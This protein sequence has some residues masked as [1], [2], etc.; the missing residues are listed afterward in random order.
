MQLG[1]TSLRMLKKLACLAVQALAVLIVD[2]R[3]KRHIVSLA[4]RWRT[5]YRRRV[6]KEW[7]GSA[8]AIAGQDPVTSQ[9]TD[10]HFVKSDGRAPADVHLRRRDYLTPDEVKRLLAAARSGRHGARPSHAVADVP[11][12]AAGQRVDRPAADDL[13]LTSDQLWVQLLK[14]GLSTSQQPARDELRAVRRHLGGHALAHAGRDLRLIQDYLG[15]RDG[16]LEAADAIREVIDRVIVTPG[17]RHGSYSAPPARRAWHDPRL[18]RA[19]RKTR[20]QI[21]RREQGAAIP[22]GGGQR[23]DQRQVHRNGAAIEWQ[24]RR[25]REEPRVHPCSVAAIIERQLGHEVMG[26]VQGGSVSW[27]LGRQ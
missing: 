26:V 21:C 25:D 2:M 24:V 19:H 1:A 17:M 5:L 27:Q 7:I 11:A 20:L 9:R 12:R 23:E 18:D 13:D 4:E 8:A 10:R 15:H 3:Q 14:H 16:A 6:C 22:G